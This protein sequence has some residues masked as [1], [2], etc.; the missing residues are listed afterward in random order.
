MK[1]LLIIIFAALLLA[2][3]S[4]KPKEKKSTGKITTEVKVTPVKNPGMPFLFR[5]K[6]EKGKHYTYKIAV[7]TEEKQTLHSDTSI[8]NNIK[9]SVVYQVNVNLNKTDKDSTMELTCNI[10]SILLDDL[11]NGQFSSYRSGTKLDSADAKKYAQ[12][13]SLVNN[14]FSVS[15][16]K[17]GGVKNVSNTDKAVSKFLQIWKSTKKVTREQR[18]TLKED[19]INGVLKPLV[20]QIFREMTPRKV[21]RDSSWTDSNPPVPFMVFKLK[22]T[23]TYKVDNLQKYNNDIVAEVDAGINA[24]V[25]GKTKFEQNGAKYNFKKPET[26]ASGKIYFNISKGL[27]QKSDVK[28]TVNIFYSME[29]PSPKGLSKGTKSDEITSRKVVELL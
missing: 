26:S 20:T 23:D 10:N 11:V 16:G 17:N 19:L 6:F 8:T 4:K 24:V 12:Y 18:N 3:C 21:A 25:S 27:L 15:I 5:Y 2:G 29:I 1:K 7:F 28:T 22:R 9:Q 14:P 13:E